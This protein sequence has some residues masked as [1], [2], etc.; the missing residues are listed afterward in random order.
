ML[1]TLCFKPYLNGIQMHRV[2]YIYNIIQ[3]QCEKCKIEILK[4]K[5]N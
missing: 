4:H 3:F 2:E 1:I 5:Y